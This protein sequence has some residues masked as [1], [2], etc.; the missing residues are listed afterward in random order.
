MRQ[1]TAPG[2]CKRYL[3]AAGL[4]FIS[5]SAS[6]A[7]P[8]ATEHRMPSVI[9]VAV[10]KTLE[11]DFFSESY[12]PTMRYLEKTF[13]NVQFVRA[14]Y[15]IKEL[16]EA[17]RAGEVDVFFADS[18][19]F[20]FLHIREHIMQVATRQAPFVE[21]PGLAQ[22]MA[23]VVRTDGPVKSLADLKDRAV[24]TEDQNRFTTWVAFEGVMSKLGS[25]PEKLSRNA[26][27]TNY[28]EPD[29]MKLLEEGR[30]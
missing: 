10:Q 17:V 13:P 25:D 28:R 1:D 2:C 14:D 24:A 3:F 9:H 26:I 22:G 11:P 7:I 5:F 15:S 18:G 6:G 8:R 16:T 23:V 27:F 19:F 21:N 12:E 4:A 20:T 29:P 30:A